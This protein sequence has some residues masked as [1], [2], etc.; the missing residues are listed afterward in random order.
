M[1]KLEEIASHN[2][3]K[4]VEFEELVEEYLKLSELFENQEQMIEELD[5]TIHNQEKIIS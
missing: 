5:K 3:E 1:T 2:C 4:E